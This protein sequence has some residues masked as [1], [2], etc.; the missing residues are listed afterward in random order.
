MATFAEMMAKARDL[1]AQGNTQDARRLAQMALAQQQ[2]EAAQ[3]TGI[4]EQGM[5]GV[6]EGI[7]ATLGMPVDAVTGVLN[8]ASGGINA[9]VGTNIPKIEDP[10]LGG[11]H[12][13]R[14]MAP[15]ISETQPQTRGQRYA[16]RVG[17]E[18]GAGA[19]LSAVGPLGLLGKMGQAAPRVLAADVLSDV[20]AGL[21]ASVAQDVAPDSA[22]AEIAGALLGGGGVAAMTPRPRADVP[23]LDDLRGVQQQAY[24]QV[25][26]TTARLTPQSTERLSANVV[27]RMTGEG[28]DDVLN[29]KASRMTRIIED[30]AGQT[31]T[32]GG[33]ENLR[34]IAG[35]NVASSLDPSEARLGAIQKQEIDDYLSSITPKD[36]IPD[37][38]NADEIIDAL[39]KG[40]EVTQRIKKTELLEGSIDR[41]ERQASTS[42]VGGNVTNTVR[43][44]I[45]AI[46][47]N[48]K[49]RRGFSA[50]EI[51]AME[52]IVRGT[53]TR[54]AARW[55][56]RF[57]PTSGNLAA[58]S[59]LGQAY[60]AATI[61]PILA[62]PAAS[63]LVGKAVG[64]RLD[65]RALADLLERVRAG[66][67]V[68]HPSNDVRRQI[69]ATLLAQQLQG[70]AE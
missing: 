16:R 23:T 63:G 10:A 1:D 56:G 3:E 2:A 46:L 30:R 58:L 53:P 6:N 40:R 27:R 66:G 11:Q 20:G 44:R 50:D 13:R 45:N 39:S 60:G 31:P 62:A 22:L 38:G 49:Q 48:P 37:S 59:G 51:R 15:T 42:G 34:R 9:L 64:E 52:D 8:L 41:A 17:Q 12:I 4:V 57:S 5:S 69:I 18:V 67:A 68:Q 36:V 35:R 14:L 25:D 21:G 70:Q 33:I 54:N 32:I 65:K 47:N 43:Q 24:R 26:E 55:L 7:A 28:I 61:N 29:P 19:P